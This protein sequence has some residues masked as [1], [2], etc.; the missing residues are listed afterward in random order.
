ML[1]STSSGKSTLLNALLGEAVLPTSHSASTSV[2][3]EIKYS[4]DPNKKFAIVHIMTDGTKHQE[5][6]DLTVSEDRKRFVAFVDKKKRGPHD[7]LSSKHKHSRQECLKVEI[8]WPLEFLQV[9]VQLIFPVCVL[10]G[11]LVDSILPWLI[12]QV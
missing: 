1:G 10:M 4:A 6:L 9:F 2:L 3:C 11:C 5:C 8:F 12:A 7:F